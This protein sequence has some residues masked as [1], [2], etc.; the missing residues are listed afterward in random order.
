MSKYRIV[1][2]DNYHAMDPDY[3]YYEKDTYETYEAALTRAKQITDQS[4]REHA[5]PGMP[6]DT[7]VG[8]WA[9]WGETPL[10]VGRGEGDPEDR[11]SARAYAKTRARL[12]VIPAEMDPPKD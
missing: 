4:L 2:L 10:I 8:N 1:I 3:E 5:E 7:I 12:Y 6:A 11:F 9:S